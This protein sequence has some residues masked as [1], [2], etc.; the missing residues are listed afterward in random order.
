MKATEVDAV[1]DDG[2]DV[3]QYFDVATSRRP[4]IEI[5][6]VNVDFPAWM[7]ASLDQ[8]ASRLAVSRQ[9]VIKT[10]IAQVLQERAVALSA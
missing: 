2:E 4:N 9:S 8:E 10:W 1:F 3:L 5:R 6:R 7:V